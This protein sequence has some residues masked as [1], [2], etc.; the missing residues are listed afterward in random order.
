VG[1]ENDSAQGAV[2]SISRQLKSSFV[3]VGGER[4]I[5]ADLSDE[6][7]AP[8]CCRPAAVKPS[9]S[10][11]W[12]SLSTPLPPDSIN[13]RDWGGVFGPSNSGAML[14]N[15]RN[16]VVP[17]HSAHR[18]SVLQ[19]IYKR[20]PPHEV[21]RL[22]PGDEII[23]V[24]P[25]ISSKLS[26]KAHPIVGQYRHAF[27]RVVDRTTRTISP[28]DRAS[29]VDDAICDRHAFI[30]SNEEYWEFA[31]RAKSYPLRE[32]LA[33]ETFDEGVIHT[34]WDQGAGIDLSVCGYTTHLSVLIKLHDVA[35]IQ[36]Y[37]RSSPDCFLSDDI[38]FNHKLCVGSKLDVPFIEQLSL[39]NGCVFSVVK[40][41]WKYYRALHLIN[42]KNLANAAGR[43]AKAI[44]A[45][46]LATSSPPDN[47]GPNGEF[48]GEFARD[49]IITIVRDELSND[50]LDQFVSVVDNAYQSSFD[51]HYSGFTLMNG[52]L[53]ERVCIRQM[54]YSMKQIF[55]FI[56]SVVS[57]I[58]SNPRG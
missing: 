19:S 52:Y 8:K 7:P 38:S 18:S 41:M 10:S 29:V 34:N 27:S 4:A 22:S 56:H 9:V 40:I 55:P 24:L 13:T 39:F 46:A 51:G 33:L 20:L 11:L 26:K 36:V 53:V 14:I 47:E 48:D 45:A 5:T 6:T 17:H 28:A 23:V 31:R 43:A 54:Y 42:H 30:R 1:H 44:A 57:S 16:S 2:R 12:L 50:N 21:V 25:A 49:G 35:F 3:D 37:P 58:A 32:H 15:Q